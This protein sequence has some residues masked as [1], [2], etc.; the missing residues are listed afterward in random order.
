MAN[1]V[2]RGVRVF[3]WAGLSVLV[4]MSVAVAAS[5]VPQV[6]RALALV[7]L[8]ATLAVVVLALAAA[9]VAAAFPWPTPVPGGANRHRATDSAA[10]AAGLPSRVTGH[11]VSRSGASVWQYDPG[12]QPC[13]SRGG[14]RNRRR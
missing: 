2:A 1:N 9:V 6:A 11:R 8:P 13:R 12:I 10:I 14:G 3:V 4:V 5:H 7:W